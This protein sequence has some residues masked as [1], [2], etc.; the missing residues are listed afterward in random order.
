MPLWI[1]GCCCRLVHEKG[2][3]AQEG[4]PHE[5]ERVLEEEPDNVLANHLL[6]TLYFHQGTLDLAIE[7]YQKALRGAPEFVL[8]YYDLGVA[9][10]YRGNMPEAIKAFRRCLEIDPH[11]NAA[12]YRLALSLFHAGRLDE[13]ALEHFE[14][15]RTLTP[16]YL[17]AN[18]HMGVAQRAPQPD[19]RGQ[20][21]VPAQPGRGGGGG[22]QHL[23]SGNDPPGGRGRRGCQ[24]AARASR[25]VQIP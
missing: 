15:A 6:G 23:P 22:E 25:R 1:N 11:Y 2:G 4:T 16:E 3:R 7:R 10:Y 9:W 21:V 8:G 18:Y 12:H 13:A 17:M 19:G 20:A 5:L 24:G 14:K